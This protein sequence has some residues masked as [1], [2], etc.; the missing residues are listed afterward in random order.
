MVHKVG[1]LSLALLTGCAEKLETPGGAVAPVSCLDLSDRLGTG[2]PFSQS[3]VLIILT[4]DI[5]TDRTAAWEAH[6]TPPP[7]PTLDALACAGTSMRRTYAHPTCSPSRATLLTGRAPSRY[8]VGRW[9]PDDGTWGLP[10][11]EV[12]LPEMM[13]EAGYASAV[14]GKWHLGP[15][16]DP[17]AA[18]HPLEQG[19]WHHRGSHANLLMALGTGHTPRGYWQW[20]RLEDGVPAWTTAYNTTVTTDDA[21]DLIDLLPEPWL[22]YVAYNSAHEPLHVPPEHLRLDPEAL[23]GETESSVLYDAM[24]TATDLEIGRLLDSI[25][26]DVLADTLVIYLSDNGTPMWGLSAPLDPARGKGTAFEGGVRVP[27]IAAGPGVSRAGT[28]AE[29][30]VGFADLF[31]TLAELVG[32][33]LATWV[34]EGAEPPAPLVLDGYSLVDVFADP[35]AASPRTTALSE[36]FHPAGAPPYDWSRATLVDGSWKYVRLEGEASTLDPAVE[37]REEL[38]RLTPTDADAGT[39]AL[40]EGTDLIADGPLDAEARAAYDRLSADFAQQLAARPFEY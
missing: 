19:F 12:T 10:L 14:A 6:P 34:P 38:Y 29:G 9:L 13:A 17:D 27:F 37:V 23:V 3:N 33:D 8:G 25:D 11:A 1:G 40:H 28:W 5:G 30:L 15:A 16:S 32:V 22:L 20:E 21:L 31:P 26:D 39:W 18:T 24:V 36:G 7:T 35:T 2:T 4:D